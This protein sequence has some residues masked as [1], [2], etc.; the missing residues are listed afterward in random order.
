MSTYP[1]EELDEMVKRWLEANERAEADNDWRT[2]LGPFYTDDCLY[3]WN[4]GP[5]DEL[6]VHGRAAIEA[7]PIGEEMLG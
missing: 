6:E 3:T 1:R 5:N 7:G 2:H 4:L